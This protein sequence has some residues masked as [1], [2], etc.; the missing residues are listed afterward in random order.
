MTDQRKL[1][2]SLLLALGTFALVGSMA[3]TGLI[4]IR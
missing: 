2:V 3:L 1:S 4:T